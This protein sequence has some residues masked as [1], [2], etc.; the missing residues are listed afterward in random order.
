MQ[1]V[2]IGEFKSRFSHLLNLVKQGEELV[3]KK[4][5]AEVDTDYHSE[6]NKGDCIPLTPALHSSPFTEWGILWGIS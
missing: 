3:I 4:V 2:T 1:N 5:P 6:G